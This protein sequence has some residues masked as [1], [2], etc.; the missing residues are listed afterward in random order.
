[1][2]NN[3]GWGGYHDQL[4]L[5]CVNVVLKNKVHMALNVADGVKVLKDLKNG[6]RPAR[7]FPSPWRHTYEKLNG[8]RLG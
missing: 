8:R 4:A 6:K 5:D 7:W 1:V 2:G 3:G